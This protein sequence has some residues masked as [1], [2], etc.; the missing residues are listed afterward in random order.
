MEILID[1]FKNIKR[2]ILKVLNHKILLKVTASCLMSLYYFTNIYGIQEA[3]T[4]LGTPGSQDVIIFGKVLFQNINRYT[5]GS[6]NILFCVFCSFILK[7]TADIIMTNVIAKTLATVQTQMFKFFQETDLS[8][9]DKHSVNGLSDLINRHVLAI[10][11]LTH[12][13]FTEFVPSLC[14]LALMWT[15]LHVKLAI[16]LYVFLALYLIIM[17]FIFP[18][19]QT[20]T[21]EQAFFA[22]RKTQNLVE[23]IQA[24]FVTKILGTNSFTFNRTIE[25][26]NQETSRK[27]I[28]FFF[29]KTL[30]SSLFTF[31]IMIAS[32]FTLFLL[33]PLNNKIALYTSFS[34]IMVLIGM[35]VGAA[36]GIY[37]NTSELIQSCKILQ[38]MEIMKEKTYIPITTIDTIEVKNLTYFLNNIKV[39]DNLCFTIN[40]KDK[41]LIFGQ[42][43]VGKSVL[44]KIL[45]KIFR[46][47][48]GLIFI[49][50]IDID[51]ISP[52]NLYKLILYFGQHSVML[53]DSVRNNI[54]FGQNECDCEFLKLDQK[55]KDIRLEQAIQSVHM[56]EKIK[57][58]GM[59]YE[60]ST[61]GANLSGGQ[62]R[63]I[64][65]ARF[66]LKDSDCIFLD[67]PTTGLS[68]NLSLEILQVVLRKDQTT[69][70]ISHDTNWNPYFKILFLMGHGRY[71]LDTHENLYKHSLEY[72][73]FFRIIES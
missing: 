61:G 6:L 14:V 57:E 29:Q 33:S 62:Q 49:N 68:S 5:L 50:G 64:D 10:E 47:D 2:Y 27:R 72:Q 48:R 63:R 59:D 7:T 40:R 31:G 21:S 3:M 26:L 37:K 42:S 54:I 53:N 39:F 17:L 56:T 70:A 69:I 23:M 30:P 46:V 60:I 28:T 15:F 18:L 1:D 35:R 8:F 41:L 52:G 32:P 45:V 66:Y 34:K 11:E 24:I 65:F 38:D 19:I 12:S 71:V 13:I 58:I 22:Y 73:R 43:G 55:D 20:K 67:E 4:L 44:M 36:G 9:Y 25:Q 51:D 16:I